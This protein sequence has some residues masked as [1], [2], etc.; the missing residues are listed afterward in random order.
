MTEKINPFLTFF[1][2]H[3][4]R[5]I[6]TTGNARSPHSLKEQND[7]LNI[8]GYDS[9]FTVNGFKNA[10]NAQKENCSSINAFFVDI[11]GRKNVEELEQIKLILHPTFIV[12]T[13]NGYHIY[14]LLDEPIYKE[15]VSTEEWLEAVTRWERIEESLV[16]NLKADSVVKDLTRILRVP[17]T[18]YWKKSGDAYKQGIK[19]VF[20]IKGIYRNEAMTYTMQQVEEVFPPV[21][22]TLS[23]ANTPTGER[24]AKFRDAERKDFF[25]RVNNEYPLVERESFIRLTSATPDSLP[26]GCGRNNA[27]LVTASLMK[28][29]GWTQKQALD[30]IKKV[31]WHGMESE[32]GGWDEIQTTIN[33]AFSKGYTYSYKNEI[34]SHNMTGEEQVKIQ[35]AFVSAV[36]QRKELDK[37]R[38]SDYEKELLLRFPYLRRNEIGI[39]YNYDNGVYKPVND[40]DLRS[41]ILRSLDDDM[42]V[43]YK[44]T[45]NVNDK[46]A[47]LLSIIP[48]LEI[49]Q[50]G[51]FTANVQNG[52]LNIYTRELKPHDP[53]FVSL[54]QYPVLYDPFATCPNWDKCMAD[55]MKGEECEGKTLL[56]QQFCGY[57]LS[58][59][60]Y[61]DRA[62]FMVGDGGNGKSTFIDTIARIIGPNAT[63]HID[64]DGLYGQF[65]M[66]GLVGKRLNI[67]EEVRG[68]YYESNKLKKLISG[69]QVTID[70]KYKEQFTFR[71]QAKFVFAV[72]QMPRVDDVSTATE[73]RICALT[74]LNNYRKN[75]NPELRSS[76]GVLAQESSGILNWMIEGAI[77]LQQAKNFVKT[78]E[79]TRMLNEYREENS[80]VEGFIK[81]CVELDAN[82]SV[83]SPL[84]YSEY[85]KW[86]QSDG[87]RKTK[88]KIT[89][90]K[91]MKAY[92][93]KEDRFT[94]EPRKFGADEAKF[95]GIRLSPHWVNQ[96][97]A[98]R[99]TGF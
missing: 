77:S 34:I 43:N 50:D 83:E 69:E 73:R 51:G 60:M 68:N 88:A 26:A 36:K 53:N 1:P 18:Y 90:T 95:V 7:E 62:L 87:G 33:S 27:L 63:S 99:D 80:S 93:A 45:K 86:C 3:I 98:F 40:L 59:S 84:L 19:E 32:R 97:N 92:G 64:L 6:D 39:L 28:Q 10:P 42:L 71:P 15:E 70:M 67:I 4:Y 61:Y 72:N 96:N 25:N 56:L 24:T 21:V 38:F 48:K 47:C 35:D 58:S 74:F 5:Y 49:T 79:Q 16:V 81:E 54:I 44:T 89:F 57:I 75:P 8:Q 29:A 11:D 78:E 65:G 41:M 76:I 31:G 20:K 12:E 17:N 66:A 46:I 37:V 55:W 30:Q 82:E 23:F 91:E 85:K 52:L 14:W 94:F 22:R 9:Y 2:D 13:K